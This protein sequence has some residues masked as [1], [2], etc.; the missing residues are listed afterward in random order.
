MFV[1]PPPVPENPV[2]PE[3]GAD[4]VPQ[5]PLRNEPEI[6]LDFVPEMG[7]RNFFRSGDGGLENSFSFTYGKSI[8]LKE[9]MIFGKLKHQK[10]LRGG[11]PPH[12][13]SSYNSEIVHLVKDFFFHFSEFVVAPPP[14]SGEMGFCGICGTS[15]GG[16]HKATTQF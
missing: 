5:I 3:R 14:R 12:P 13:H 7:L 9:K 1:A 16:G 15:R 10:F 4:F 2:S 8:F 6:P 11:K